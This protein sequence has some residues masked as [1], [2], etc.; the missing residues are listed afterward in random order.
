MSNAKSKIK[1]V[2][3]GKWSTQAVDLKEKVR[4]LPNCVSIDRYLDDEEFIHLIKKAKI[5]I[6]PYKKYAHSAVLYA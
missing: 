3:A 2:I 6:L 1:L 5:V 4:A